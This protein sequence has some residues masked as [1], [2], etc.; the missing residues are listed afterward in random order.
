MAD[1]INLRQARKAKARVQKAAEAAGNR[2]AFG[3]PKKAKTLAEARRSIEVARH[4]GHR[5]EGPDRSE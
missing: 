4:E 2:V 3:A 5:L 1:I